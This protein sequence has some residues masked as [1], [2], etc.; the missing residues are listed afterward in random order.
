MAELISKNF[1]SA[2]FITDKE[3]FVIKASEEMDKFTGFKTEGK[4]LTKIF[5]VENETFIKTELESA[6]SNLAEKKIQFEFFDGLLIKRLCL[7]ALPF[8]QGESFIGVVCVISSFS[9]IGEKASENSGVSKKG[10]K[11]KFERRA[12]N[13]AKTNKILLEE[14]KRKM[15]IE[16]ELRYFA[17][18]DALTGIYN[19]RAG[20]L[21]LEHR[22]N[23]SLRDKTP[24][25]I[26]FVDVN[27]LKNINDSY[28]H[29]E[30]D[31]LLV[32]LTEIL[33]R[34]VRESDVVFRLGG[35]EFIIIFQS[36]A[37]EN[38]DLIWNRIMNS[39]DEYNI[40]EEKNYSISLS[41][42]F[43]IFDPSKPK[44]IEELISF[45]DLEMYRKKEDF[46]KNHGKASV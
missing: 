23:E 18:T 25:L 13:L 21:F 24:F 4:N 8:K 10:L 41:Y 37:M 16:E 45:A 36:L 38:T 15:D 39:L 22:I 34:S 20:L 19:R 3:L 12:S 11:D 32:K 35:D 26:C 43:A 33:N 7:K 31:N 1:G 40:K 44:S 5:G 46:Y 42:G 17:S 2:V 30:G 28:G 29:N 6:I 14:L 9:E 27:G